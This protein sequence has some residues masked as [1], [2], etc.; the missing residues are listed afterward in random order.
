MRPPPWRAHERHAAEREPHGAHE[1]ELEARVPV[2]VGQLEHA[3]RRALAGVVHEH[4]DAAEAVARRARGRAPRPPASRRR[5]RPPRPRGRAARIS[6][7][8]ASSA[9]RPAR[10]RSPGRRPSPASSSAIA[11]PMPLLAPVTTATRSV[12]L[13]CTW[14][15]HTGRAELVNRTRL[16]GAEAP[17]ACPRAP[18][19]RRAPASARS[20]ARRC[21]V[22]CA[23]TARSSASKVPVSTT[24]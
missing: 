23:S 22:A 11:R 21:A 24:P 9:A 14:L 6:A 3:L 17:A 13:G 19:R 16:R 15:H 4:V 5:R 12:A 7:A 8:T 18:V 20:G 10:V 1:V 2:V